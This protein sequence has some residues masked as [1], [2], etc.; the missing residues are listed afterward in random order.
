MIIKA[1]QKRFNER[2]CG[3]KMVNNVCERCPGEAEFKIQ[4][5][6]KVQIFKISLL[7][8]YLPQSRQS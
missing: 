4:M 3:K 7:F 6:S 2:I 1:C 5:M 8:R